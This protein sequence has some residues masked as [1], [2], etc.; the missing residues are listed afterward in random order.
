MDDS[1]STGAAG[2]IISLK[3]KRHSLLSN[4]KRVMSFCA[5]ISYRIEKEM[6]PSWMGTV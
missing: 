1:D 5:F 6:K 2:Q 4:L 3:I